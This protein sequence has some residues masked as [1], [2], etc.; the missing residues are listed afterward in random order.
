MAARTPPSVRYTYI[1]SLEV[2]ISFSG[3][4]K[5]NALPNNIIGISLSQGIV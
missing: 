4:Y 1:A 3:L 2:F 5:R